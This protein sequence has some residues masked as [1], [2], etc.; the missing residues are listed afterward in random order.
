M[1][2]DEELV[3]LD[4]A[5]EV[6]SVQDFRTA[7]ERA[8]LRRAPDDKALE[9]TLAEIL[10]SLRSRDAAEV[11]GAIDALIEAGGPAV[12]GLIPFATS[13]LEVVT[14]TVGFVFRRVGCR[15]GRAFTGT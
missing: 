11:Q 8:P 7:Y 9:A 14:A 5:G 13:E 3:Y 6:R 10:P 4:V 2:G 1:V 15:G 12:G